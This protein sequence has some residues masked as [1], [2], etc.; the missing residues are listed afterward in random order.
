MRQLAERAYFVLCLALGRLLRSTRYSAVRIAVQDADLRVRKH[1]L[2]YASLLVWLGE[3][4]MQILNTG[5]RFLH[6]G[7]WA[8][9]ERVV[10]RRVYGSS[11][12]IEARGVLLLP[13]LP[14]RT[15]A[16]VLEDP[17]VVESVRQRAIVR[18]V[19]ALAEFHRLGFTHGDAMAENV[20][21]DFEDGVAR[22]FDFETVHDS[23]R[24]TTW[25]RADDV[26][27]LLSS[28]LLRTVTKRRAGILQ[29]ILDSYADEAVIRVL[30][31]S[32]V[33]AWQR[34]LT[35]HLGQAA[36]SFQC[37][38]EIAG[39]LMERVE[40]RTYIGDRKDPGTQELTHA[41]K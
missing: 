41:E 33:S 10:Y 36:L 12:S 21:V 3:P 7:D 34:S 39:L 5:V 18:A 32:F 6:Q 30:T 8:E 25:R 11:I 22:W 28:C 40:S 15:L 16:E 26:R 29:L 2:F 37:F 38:E 4:L 20:L 35:F 19:V 27:A 23:N 1:R 9:R 13:V 31:S 14:G 17:D 24:P